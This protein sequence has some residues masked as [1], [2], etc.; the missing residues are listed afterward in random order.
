MCSLS[1]KT[2]LE[3]CRN[4]VALMFSDKLETLKNSLI[5]NIT[6][7]SVDYV[8]YKII[9]LKHSALQNHRCIIN[10]ILLHRFY[11]KLTLRIYIKTFHISNV[12]VF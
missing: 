5:A 6:V 12:L 3:I 9:K 2:I 8:V 4:Q 11:D 1:M 10:T 7:Y